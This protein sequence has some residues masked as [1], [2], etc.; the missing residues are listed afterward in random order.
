MKNTRYRVGPTRPKKMRYVKGIPFTEH[1]A[2]IA[3]T[4]QLLDFVQTPRFPE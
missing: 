3:G 2:E 1:D 4:A